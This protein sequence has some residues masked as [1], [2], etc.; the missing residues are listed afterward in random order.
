MLRFLA[1]FQLHSNT[2][3]T[4]QFIQ[5]CI[6]L[7]KKRDPVLERHQA[8][9]ILYCSTSLVSAGY[10]PWG[11]LDPIRHGALDPL[12]VAQ[13]VGESDP[14]FSRSLETLSDILWIFWM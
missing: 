4:E 5:N 6:S 9:I 12:T 13:T 7:E 2:N 1:Q 14:V 8:G 3:L 10:A 11:P